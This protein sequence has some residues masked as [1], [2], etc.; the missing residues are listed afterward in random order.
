MDTLFH[1]DIEAEQTDSHVLIH[2]SNPIVGF[3]SFDICMKTGM[4]H[5]DDVGKELTHKII[6][7]WLQPQT[8]STSKN[9]CHEIVEYECPLRDGTKGIFVSYVFKDEDTCEFDQTR[10]CIVSRPNETII[11]Q[12]FF[13]QRMDNVYQARRYVKEYLTSAGVT[14][15]QR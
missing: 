12:G 9:F 10:I 8:A 3:G 13:K 4:V 14:V 5:S 11:Q 2:W 6:R 1:F 7:D 15:L